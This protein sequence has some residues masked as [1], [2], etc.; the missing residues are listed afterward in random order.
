MRDR[1]RERERERERAP[2]QVEMSCAKVLWWGRDI[3]KEVKENMCLK[4]SRKGVQILQN[5]ASM[6]VGPIIQ[7]LVY[8]VKDTDLYSG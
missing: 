6:G 7:R 1:E 5:V 4:N 8:S 2:V 3:F